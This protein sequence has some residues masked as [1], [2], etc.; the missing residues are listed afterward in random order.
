MKKQFDKA[1]YDENDYR[2][3]LA[4]STYLTST[5][6]HVVDNPDKYGPDLIIF[7]GFKPGRYVEVEVKRV[8]MGQVFPWSSVQLPER[9]GKFLRKKLPIEFWILNNDLKFSLVIADKSLLKERIEVVP[10]KLVPAGEKFY[11]IP[12]AE[13]MRVSL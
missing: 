8:W 5:G 3:R 13:C 11:R 9:K 6:L 2:A 7:Q 4:V 10:N 1:L 12:I